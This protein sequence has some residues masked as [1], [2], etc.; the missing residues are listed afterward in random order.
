MRR[1]DALEVRAAQFDTPPRNFFA[2]VLALFVQYAGRLGAGFGMVI[3]I[4]VGAV[5]AAVAIPAYADY[6]AKAQIAGAM[7]ESQAARS[8]LASYYDDKQ[9]IPETLESIGQP[10]QLASGV[11]LTLDPEALVLSVTTKNNETIVYT[12][13]KDAVAKITWRCA[14]D[15]DLKASLLPK[16]CH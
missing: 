9:A 15:E 4:Y 7:L 12:P 2:Y 6:K 10:A 5:I 16:D 8:A 1:Y 11:Q 13:E 14:G 3:I